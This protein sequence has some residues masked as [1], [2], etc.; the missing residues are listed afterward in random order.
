[1]SEE[2]SIDSQNRIIQ[3]RQRLENAEITVRARSYTFWI[4]TEIPKEEKGLVLKFSHDY[5]SY[6]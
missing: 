1:M 5:E 4:Y 6:M 3:L 2:Q